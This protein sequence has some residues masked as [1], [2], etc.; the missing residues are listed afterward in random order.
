[1]PDAQRIVIRI[2]KGTDGRTALSCIRA[3]GTTTWQRKEGAQATFFPKHDLTHYAVETALGHR[4]GFY[5][6]V[7]AGWDFSDFGSPWPRGSLPV[8]ASISEMIVG[9]LDLERR[10][11]ERSTADELSQKLAEYAIE[12]GLPPQRQLTEEDLARVREKRAEMFARW[13]AVQPGD[14]LE[15]PFEVAQ[16]SLRDEPAPYRPRNGAA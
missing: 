7:S 13:D 16:A 11:G 15:I 9:V 10:T 6:L 12:H 3:D 1:M 4:Q 8:E 5:G 2:K 14:A